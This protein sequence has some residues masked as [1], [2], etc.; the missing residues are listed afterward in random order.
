MPM[1]LYIWVL[2]YVDEQPAESGQRC[3][4]PRPEQICQ[5]VVELRLREGAG[6]RPSGS[7]FSQERR[8]E[9]VFLVVMVRVDQLLVDLVGL[10]L[11]VKQELHR[12]AVL[13]QEP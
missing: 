13:G 3:V 7:L 10:V 11:P 8:D 6:L 12:V 4:H 5:Q 1:Y 9:V 2:G